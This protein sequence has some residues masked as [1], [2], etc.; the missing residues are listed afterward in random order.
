MDINKKSQLIQKTALVFILMVVIL[1]FFFVFL[2]KVREVYSKN[3]DKGICATSVLA[4]DRFSLLD[5]YVVVGSGKVTEL[6]LRCPTKKITI[7]NKGEESTKERLAR[8]LYGVCQEFNQGNLD[9]FGNE[10]GI[11]C[12]IRE[13]VEFKNKGKKIKG[14]LPYLEENNPPGQDISF[15]KYCNPH[16]TADI[17]RIYS[18]MT[19]EQRQKFEGEYIDTDKR[20]AIIFLY[21]KGEESIKRLANT[22]VGD[23]PTH[24][25]M[26]IALGSFAVLS[27]FVSLPLTIA[28]GLLSTAGISAYFSWIFEQ[29]PQHASFFLIRE[30]NREELSKLGCEKV[31]GK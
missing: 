14:F 10:E 1:T 19:P 3:A 30:Y 12:V 11:F 7:D 23:S 4:N 24:I 13:L 15:S 9:L 17:E 31:V 20:Y 2:G 16:R 22:F 25:T 6:H 8:E 29:N 21:A 28:A 5:R 18:E 26:Y 27:S